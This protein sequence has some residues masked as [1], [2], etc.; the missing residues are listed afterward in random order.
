MNQDCMM[1]IRI[2]LAYQLRSLGAEYWKAGLLFC[3]VKGSVQY[4]LIDIKIRF[5]H[6]FIANFRVIRNS[7][8]KP[9]VLQPS[10]VYVETLF[11]NEMSLRCG[12]L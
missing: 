7:F 4:L 3:N 11:S 1:G 9:A 12:D 6:Y 5:S 8:V 10:G 2:S